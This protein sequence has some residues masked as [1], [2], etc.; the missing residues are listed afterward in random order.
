MGQSQSHRRDSRYSRK[1]EAILN[2]FTSRELNHP[3]ADEIY[4]YL[5]KKFPTISL[6]TVYRNLNELVELGKIIKIEIPSAPARFDFFQSEHTHIACSN[7]GRVFDAP[8]LS[9]EKLKESAPKGFIIKKVSIC[10]V[11]ICADCL[12]SQSV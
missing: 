9:Q 6:G 2:S 7:C 8:A 11:G 12:K 5:R 3:T 1:G 10:A 4:L